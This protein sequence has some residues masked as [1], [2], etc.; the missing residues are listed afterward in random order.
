MPIGL[1]GT[2]VSG[3][4]QLLAAVKGAVKGEQ[5]MSSHTGRKVFC[6]LFV[7]KPSPGVS[8]YVA[9]IGKSQTGAS[10]ETVFCSHCLLQIVPGATS[11]SAA[12]RSVLLQGP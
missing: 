3:Q 8:F 7:Q 9:Y 2:S 5:Q 4:K 12:S 10:L 11:Y 6:C 1:L